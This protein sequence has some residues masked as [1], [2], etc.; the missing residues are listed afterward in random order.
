MIVLGS[1]PFGR[2]LDHESGALLNGISALIKEVSLRFL[3][4]Y[5]MWEHNEKSATQNQAFIQ[6]CV[7]VCVCVPTRTRARAHTQV[8]A[9]ACT[10]SV[11]SDSCYYRDY[12]LPVSSVHGIFQA[13]ILEQVAIC[14]ST[15]SS[16]ARDQT[17]TSCISC[18]GSG[19]FTTVLLGSCHSTIP[20]P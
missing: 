16:G 6:S 1:G 4:S 20:V 11:K 2:V 5:S 3:A 13:R 7:C 9:Q 18:I 8:R 17:H 19:F 10:H 15:G 12:S 14:Y